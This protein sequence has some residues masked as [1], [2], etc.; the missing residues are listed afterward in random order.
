MDSEGHPQNGLIG[1]VLSASAN[2]VVVDLYGREVSLNKRMV[3]VKAKFGSRAH[4]LMSM[5][6]MHWDLDHLDDVGL[7]V[8]MD[9][10]LWMRDYDWCKD[11]HMRMTQM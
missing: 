1:K 10:A 7:F 6:A 9:I 2:H 5:K 3:R 4:S 8:L 11:I